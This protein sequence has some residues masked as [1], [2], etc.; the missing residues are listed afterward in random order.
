VAYG[1]GT[2]VDLDVPAA[3]ERVTAALTEQGFGVLTRID[4]HDVLRAKI[5]ADIE[6][7]VI[8]GACSPELAK[9]AIEEEP[10]VGLLLPCNVLVRGVR[11]ETQV[12][13]ID[14]AALGALAD[15]AA[16]EVPMREARERLQAAL[17][18]L[19]GSAVE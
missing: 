5:G 7:Y 17:A 10:E 8:L 12:S 19:R 11:G 6:P 14:P 3:V 9:R 1:F 13:F 15:N 2:T 16:L 18:S 4:V